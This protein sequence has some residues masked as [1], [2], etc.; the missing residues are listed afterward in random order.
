M[1]ATALNP[2]RSRIETEVLRI[3]GLLEKSRFEE[4]LGAGQTLLGDVPENR[5]VLYMI[6]VS[7]RYLGRIHEALATLSRFEALH[8]EYSR[9]YQE[10]GH[11]HVAA[12]NAP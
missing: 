12:R 4:A 2:P 7:Q 6:A 5:D 1:A 10:Q 9:L 11:C 8:P 3:R